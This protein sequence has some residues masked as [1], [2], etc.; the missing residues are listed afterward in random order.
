MISDA[1]MNDLKK[2]L[3]DEKMLL[4]GQLS[5][6]GQRDPQNPNDWV[7]AKSDD[8]TFGADRNDNADIIEEM[9]DNNASMN[10]LEERLNEVTSALSKMD[11]GTYG[12]CETCNNPIEPERL[13]ANPAARTCKEHMNAGTA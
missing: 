10:E 6:L 12:V 4:E 11:T 7:P 9:Q 1:G 5:R 2:A 8:D 3:T 13:N